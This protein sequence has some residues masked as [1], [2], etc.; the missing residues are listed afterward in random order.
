[1][2]YD[3]TE[4]QIGNDVYKLRDGQQ[5]DEIEEL[6]EK[7]NAE[8]LNSDSM[9]SINS[10][11]PLNGKKW[12]VCGDSF[13]AGDFNGESDYTFPDGKYAKQNKVYAR[14]ISLRNNMTL[15][16]LATGGKTLANPADGSFF[17][18]FTNLNSASGNSG[19]KNYKDIDS[20][21][22]YITFYFGINDSHHEPNSSG[23]DGEDKTGSIPLGTLSDTTTATFYG[24][25][26]V[27]LEWLTENRPYAHMGILVSNGCDR[28]AYRIATIEIANKWG[29]PYIDLNG[30]AKTPM[31]SRST[32]PAISSVVKEIKNRLYRVSS[33]NAHPNT[34]A[35][36]YESWFIEDF[37]RSL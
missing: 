7:I 36:L 2:T 8:I 15:Q 17:N 34:S 25:W 32:N 27:M 4:L 11:N 6:K 21:V 23:D 18:S 16:F 28:D 31:M 14:H 3:V 12:A 24:A 22:D 26:N 19:W 5:Y 20:D 1:M 29:V 9:I 35:H 33:T 30:D 13:T 10:Y 37:L